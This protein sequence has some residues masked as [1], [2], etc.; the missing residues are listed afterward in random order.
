MVFQG[1]AGAGLNLAF[2]DAL[3]EA[4]PRDRQAQFVAINMTAVHLMG[5]IGPPIGAALLAVM[6]IRWVLVT[7]TIVAFS[8][9]SVFAFV[10]PGKDK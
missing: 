10:R 7:A 5:V 2:F 6:D 4:C 8:G 1:L 3:L 9:V